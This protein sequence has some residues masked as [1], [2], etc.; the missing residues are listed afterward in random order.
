M[1]VIKFYLGWVSIR[2]K[3]SK[4][5]DSLSSAFFSLAEA[6]FFFVFCF[7]VTQHYI[8]LYCNVFVHYTA[9]KYEKRITQDKPFDAINEIRIDHFLKE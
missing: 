2:V 6:A 5:L 4:K 1:Y 3:Y 9:S 7:F 8:T